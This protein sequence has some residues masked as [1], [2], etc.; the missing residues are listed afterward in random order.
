[1]ETKMREELEKEKLKKII[2]D[3]LMKANKNNDM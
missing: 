2:K 3:I 1:M